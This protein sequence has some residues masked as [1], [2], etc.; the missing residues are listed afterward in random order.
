MKKDFQNISSELLE[1]YSKKLKVNSC[2]HCNS[3]RFIKHS[4]YKYTQRFKCLECGR[5]FIPSTGTSLHYLHKKEVFLEYSKIIREQGLLSLKKM[6]E[7]C[8]I[9]HLTAFDWRHKILLSIPESN[10]RFKGEVYCDDIWFVYSEKGRKLVAEARRG[11]LRDPFKHREFTCRLISLSDG[12]NTEMKLVKVGNINFSDYCPAFEDKIGRK[13]VI[14]NVS[15]EE[16]LRRFAKEQAA[17]HRFVLDTNKR[18]EEKYFVIRNELK[19]FINKTLKGVSTKYLQMYAGYYSYS[20]HKIF[21]PLSEAF[22]NRRKVWFTYTRLEVIYFKFVYF[23][24]QV[25]LIDLNKRT[26]KSTEKVPIP[27]NCMV[28]K[29]TEWDVDHRHSFKEVKSYFDRKIR[30]FKSFMHDKKD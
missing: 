20:K 13:S 21:D 10:R 7:L 28:Y 16:K 30:E 29:I 17:K 6:R 14:Y 15:G 2:P 27:D 19:G 5:T 23:A 1:I 8:N 24:T 26:W 9:S 11:P 22:L 3:K 4:R 25:L 12:K 18:I